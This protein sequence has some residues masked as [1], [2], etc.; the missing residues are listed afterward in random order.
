ML[1]LTSTIAW[2]CWCSR[3][4]GTG[5]GV[6]FHSLFQFFADGAQRR[7][8]HQR[9]VQPVRVLR[10]MLAA[11]YGL[12]LHGYNLR[13]IQAGMQYIAINLVASLLFL[14]GRR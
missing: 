14:I 11:S 4:A 3:R 6:H 7:L 1:V 8:P 10:V 2:P 13:R 12:V 9:P 5:S